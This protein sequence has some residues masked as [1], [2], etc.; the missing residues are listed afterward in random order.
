MSRCTESPTIAFIGGNN[1]T[2]AIVG[3]LI[4]RSYPPSGILE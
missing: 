3:G 1:M 2:T 4:A